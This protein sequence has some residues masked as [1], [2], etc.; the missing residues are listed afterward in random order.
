MNKYPNYPPANGMN[1]AAG[2]MPSNKKINNQNN[3]HQKKDLSFTEKLRKIDKH[4]S[5]ASEFR[6]HTRQGALLSTLFLLIATY[7]L[8]F[9]INFN[10]TPTIREKVH[11]NS[12]NPSGIE[13]EID[14]TFPSVPCA[15]L[16][17]DS[18]DPN[19]QRQSL[20]LDADH[21]VWKHRISKEGNK[22][23]GRTKS[24]LA[25]T[26]LFEKH[27]EDLA[28]QDALPFLEDYDDA[29]HDDEEYG[30]GSCYGAG[31]EGECCNTCD[32]VKR[33]YKRK[34][35]H[36]DGKKIDVRQCRNEVKS[37]DEHGEGCNIHGIV[38]LSS[39]GGNVHI[40]PGRDMENFGQT[41][42][43]QN[44]FDL[45][46][47]AFETFNVSHTVHKLRFGREYPGHIHQLDGANRMIEDAYG[48]YQYYIQVVPTTYKFLNGT[49]IQT[50]Q[51]SVTEH[52][53][54]VSPGSNR[55]L[56]GVFFFYEVSPL[57]VDIEEYRRGFVHFF[58]GV[59]SVIG[60][61]YSLMSMADAYIFSKSSS[62]S[63][64]GR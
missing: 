33:A 34:G 57:H 42:F 19:G 10:F 48:M 50:N 36:F 8:Y 24:E 45:I 53:R 44:I 20:H 29:L 58:T 49:I 5:V 37:D 23:G 28:S 17:I 16:N 46:N 59:C 31:D 43:F 7:L 9:E 3:P 56:P 54:H 52:M 63:G 21:H 47:Q 32:D 15:L 26:L 2:A 12:T 41:M 4:T 61:V 62:S 55:G 60:G 51:Y 30:C 13:I 40:A 39:G 6:V 25:A 18:Q 64:L 38:A 11:V 35:W 27:I 1:H 14:V 22:I